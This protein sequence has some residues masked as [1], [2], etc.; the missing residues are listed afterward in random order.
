M[1]T[2]KI[3]VLNNFKPDW[4]Q[5]DETQADYIKNK[6]TLGTLAE[7]DSEIY[8][9]SGEMPEGYVLQID[10]EGTASTIPTKTSEL[11]NDSGF[12]TAIDLPTKTSQLINDSGFIT[13]KDLP[14][15]ELPSVTEADNG[16]VLRVVNGVWSKD[17]IP[18]VSGGSV[19]GEF[20][21]IEEILIGESIAEFKRDVEP[22]G[23][24]YDFKWIYIY[25]YSPNTN[26]AH[27][28]RFY[29]YNDS[30]K[31]LFSPSVAFTNGNDYMAIGVADMFGG[32]SQNAFFIS[33]ARENVSTI[34]SSMNMMFDEHITKINFKI[35]TNESVLMKDDI[36]KIYGVR[37]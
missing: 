20:E 23:T 2:Y 1:P 19:I 6:P 28:G 21:L 31:N 11:E 25:L 9:G 24:P 7:K 14:N 29:L 13:L 35:P 5:T 34:N 4:N 12:I 30:G 3:Q 26:A 18:A 32:C 22:D 27:G 17:E 10:P 33:M 36:I 16:K 37:W 8:I 15:P